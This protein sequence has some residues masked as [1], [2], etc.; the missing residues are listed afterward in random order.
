MK[1]SKRLKNVPWWAYLLLAIGVFFF[2]PDPLDLVLGI[3]VVAE[4]IAGIIGM[5]ITVVELKK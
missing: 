2:I 1:L 5:I 4:A 3:G